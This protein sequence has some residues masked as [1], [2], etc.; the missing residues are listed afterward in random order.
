MPIVRQAFAVTRNHDFVPEEGVSPWLSSCRLPEAALRHPFG[1]ARSLPATQWQTSSQVT[2]C[3]NPGRNRAAAS[4][5]RLQVMDAIQTCNSGCCFRSKKS[6]FPY[7]PRNRGQSTPIHGRNP[8]APSTLKRNQLRDGQSNPSR[9]TEM[10]RT[11]KRYP[12][13]LAESRDWRQCKERSLPDIRV[14]PLQFGHFRRIPAR[15]IRESS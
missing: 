15:Y 2:R 1:K 10:N 5:C 8:E 9:L 6:V 3:H 13:L 4:N 7:L 12:A 11:L 14:K